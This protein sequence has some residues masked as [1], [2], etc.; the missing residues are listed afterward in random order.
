MTQSFALHIFFKLSEVTDIKFYTVSLKKAPR[1][2]INENIKN[3]STFV[4][5]ILH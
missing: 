1:V 2:N 4:K 3:P 5:G